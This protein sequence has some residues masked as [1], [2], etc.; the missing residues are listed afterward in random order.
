MLFRS[1]SEQF[2]IELFDQ[3]AFFAGYGFNKSHSVPYA[4]LAYQTAYLKANYPAEYIAASLTAVKRDKDRTAIFL[5]EARD[6]GV[7]VSTPDINRS[8]SDFTV[9]DNEILFGL[10]AVRN[11]GDITSEKIVLERNET[12]MLLS[13]TSSSSSFQFLLFLF[14]SFCFGLH[15]LEI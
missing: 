6:M 9:N 15:T 10:S 8:A 11:V 4:L 13:N 1:Y 3:I 5:S 14:I 2:A 7:K 12:M